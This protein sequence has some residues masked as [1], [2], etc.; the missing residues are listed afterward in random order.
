MGGG[1]GGCRKLTF[2]MATMEASFAAGSLLILAYGKC[3]IN[4]YSKI[5]DT[6]ASANS[7]DLGSTLFA[8]PLSL[9]RNN[10]IKSKI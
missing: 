2:K 1:G 9:L 7:A 3:P 6:T 4:S 10:C 8:I 5:S